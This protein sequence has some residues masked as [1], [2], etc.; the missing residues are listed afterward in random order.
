MIGK[1]RVDYFSS[2]NIKYH[3]A[4]KQKIKTNLPPFADVKNLIN[5]LFTPKSSPSCALIWN[6][7]CVVRITLYRCFLT[8]SATVKYFHLV[9]NYSHGLMILFYQPQK[10]INASVLVIN[11]THT[12]RFVP[13]VLLEV[14]SSMPLHLCL[15]LLQELQSRIS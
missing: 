3:G 6:Q 14:K 2:T 8:W 15:H 11:S 9:V 5:N 10:L 12:V 1:L 7:H 4:M 13:V